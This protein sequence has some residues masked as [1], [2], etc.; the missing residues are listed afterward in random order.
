MHA[1]PAS[2]ARV[3]SSELVGACELR[4]KLHHFSAL[5][6]RFGA[7]MAR[8]AP[9]EW[10]EL[11][12]KMLPEVQGVEGRV[13]AWMGMVREDRFSELECATELAK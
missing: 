11:G 7:T 8:C 4:G 12:A 1:L 2:L 6:K 5:N 10:V 9:D 3:E 13:D